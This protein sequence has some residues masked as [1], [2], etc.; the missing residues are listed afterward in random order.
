MYRKILGIALLLLGLNVSAQVT[1]PLLNCLDDRQNFPFTAK[2]NGQTATLTFKGWKY[3]LP[4]K[5]AYVDA[6]GL[7]WS[8]YENQEIYVATTFPF[9]K[10]VTI[11]TGGSSPPRHI[12][13]TYCD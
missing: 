1:S 12:A 11:Q 4:Y 7:R 2:F 3:D 8:T 9:D 13:G 6:K 10:F 5:G